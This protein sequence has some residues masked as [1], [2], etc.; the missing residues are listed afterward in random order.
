MNIGI[1]GNTNKDR[2][3]Q[4]AAQ[5]VAWFLEE[6]NA[7]CLHEDVARGLVERNLVDAATCEAHTVTDL[8]TVADIILSFGGDGTMLNSA[9]EVGAKSTPLLGINIGRLGFLADVEVGDIQ[10]AMRLLFDG[11]YRIEPRLVLE[12]ELSVGGKKRTYFA[13]NEFVLER[14]GP[15][16]LLSIEVTVDGTPLNT[17]WADG[18]ILATPTGST[19]YSLAVGGPIVMPG[20]DVVILS[21]VAPHSLTVRPFVLPASSVVEARIKTQKHPYVL[22]ADGRSTLLRHDEVC[23]RVHQAA[24]RLNLVKFPHQHYFKTLRS[25]LMWGKRNE[26]E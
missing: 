26:I 4:P 24:H 19:A 1:T 20:S 3:W 2:L 21:P 16:G 10:A 5:L 12:A 9:H 13:L 25:K 6:G 14:G 18:L 23:I 7:F 22:A 15:V 8:A 17:Y 11:R